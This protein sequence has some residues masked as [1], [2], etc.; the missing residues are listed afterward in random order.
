MERLIDS[1]KEEE[2]SPYGTQLFKKKRMQNAQK[3]KKDMMIGF[4]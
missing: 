4:L 2:S 3:Y 1:P